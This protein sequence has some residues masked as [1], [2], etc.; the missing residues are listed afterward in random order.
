MVRTTRELSIT[1]PNKMADAIRARVHS[2]EYAS[3]SEA[4]LG[5]LRALFARDRAVEQWLR[6]EVGAAYYALAADPARAVTVNRV[7]ERLA[8]EHSPHQ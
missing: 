8:A 1:L 5:G 4:L 2:G 7:R 6:N 3:E